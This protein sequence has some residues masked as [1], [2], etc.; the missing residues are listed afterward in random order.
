MSE[1]PI[2]PAGR[3]VL[4]NG[5]S[6]SGKSSIANALVTLFDE[7]HLLMSVDRFY[8]MLPRAGAALS[9]PVSEEE[10]VRRTQAGFHRAVAGM[11]AA[12]NHLVIDQVLSRPWRLPDLLSV[13]DGFAVTFVGV[14][15]PPDELAR[16]ERARGDRRVG[17]AAAQL[18]VVHAHG[19]YDVECDTSV[20]TPQACAEHIK[21]QMDGRTTR[22]AFDVLRDRVAS[23]EG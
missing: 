5:A 19:L 8:A 18:P 1:A 10:A 22:R 2:V 11:A 15:C 9:G 13:L 6:S 4:L 16:R 12:G 17:Q 14:H 20:L 21:R 3:I 23:G 7:P